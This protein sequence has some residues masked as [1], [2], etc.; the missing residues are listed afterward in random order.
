MKKYILALDQGTTSS[1]SI[2]FDGGKPLYIAQREYPQIYPRPGWVE[3]DPMDIW[4]SQYTTAE[5]V[6]K[7]AAEDGI[8]VQDIAAI[9][10]TNQRET[11]ILWDRKTGEPAYNAIV[12]QC[13]RS[14]D[15]C[16]RLKEQG[17]ADKIHRKTGLVPDPYFSATKLMWLFENIP[18]L[19][20][21]AKAGELAFGTPDCWLTYKLSGGKYH[22][23][24]RTNASRTMLFNINTLSWDEELLEEFNIPRGILPQVVP[25]SGVCAYTDVSL[26][27]SEIP[28]AGIAGDQQA[29]L[30]GQDCVNAGDMK[31][32]YGT[33]CFMLMNV[34]GR[35]VFSENGLVTTVCAAKNGG[36]AYAL[37]GSVFS[38]GCAVQWL[39]DGLKLI[40][41]AS[42]TEE[43]AL[44]VPDTNGVY[45]VPAFTG[46][47][48]PKW[49]PDARG[50]ICGLTRGAE[51]AH[52]VRAVLESIAYQ[53]EDLLSLMAMESGVR[54]DLRVDGGACANDFLMQFQADISG[55]RVV[56]RSC[57]ETTA[58][59][60][61]RLAAEA[62]NVDFASDG[63][64]DTVFIP[65]MTEKERADKLDGWHRAVEKALP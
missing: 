10:I 8:T 7:K 29:S 16:A 49:E 1:R 65:K 23:T 32:T 46:L 64:E 5:E 4:G 39:R 51:R 59:G 55:V 50:I 12:W 9:G 28:I 37:E 6:L 61:A 24:D 40:S 11:A 57:L 15:I 27:G 47:G 22:V 54:G 25:S 45:M 13:R 38:G 41:R 48:A 44:S 30:Y 3:H 36:A 19:L 43:I 60:A 53:S 18:G 42:E 56:R 17:L 2:I 14:A 26:F 31:N 58:L 63:G 33:G 62:V 34:G 35:P 20:E 21:R 52:I